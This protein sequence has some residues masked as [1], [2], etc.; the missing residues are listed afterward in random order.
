MAPP[1]VGDVWTALSSEG[2]D[3][4]GVDRTA[5]RAK[6]ELDGV[7]QRLRAAGLTV[8]ASVIVNANP[9]R[10]LI[11]EIARTGADI[12]ALSTAGRGLSRL[13]VGS[14]ADK[15][16]RACERPTLIRRPPSDAAAR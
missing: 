16:L 6:A 11:D 7:A 13:I 9:A 2:L 1:L 15:V 8:D 14:V 4:F 10:A 3:R 12:V 5:E